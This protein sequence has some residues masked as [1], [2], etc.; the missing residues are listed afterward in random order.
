MYVLSQADGTKFYYCLNK[1]RNSIQLGQIQINL[2]I[3]LARSL[4]Y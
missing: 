1:N 2:L 4:A 3:A